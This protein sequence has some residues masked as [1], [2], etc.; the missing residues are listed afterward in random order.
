M[1]VE[2][3]NHPV[4]EQI[5]RYEWRLAIVE[6]GKGQLS[7]GI[8]EGLLV[9]PPHALERADVEGILCATV[10]GTFALELAVRFFVGLGLLQRGELALTQHQ[11]F[12]RALGFQRFEPLLH[13]LEIVALPDAAHAGRRYVQPAPLQF[14]SDSHLPPGRLGDRELHHR[15]LDLGRFDS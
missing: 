3:R 6:L 12:L 13:G 8:E 4:I 10:T 15:L 7:V 5:G 9:N 14:I 2:E 1:L 11:S